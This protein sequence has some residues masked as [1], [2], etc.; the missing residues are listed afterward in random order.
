[1]TL[2]WKEYLAAGGIALL[3]LL[4]A[5]VNLP[6]L[7]LPDW[8]KKILDAMLGAWDSLKAFFTNSGTSQGTGGDILAN[9][10]AGGQQDTGSPVATAGGDPGGSTSGTVFKGNVPYHAQ[11]DAN[12]E[13]IPGTL[14]AIG[15]NQ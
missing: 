1:M 2:T 9:Q 10:G 12:G 7:S 4:V 14:Q 11:F 15:P 3:A 5:Y 8:L 13:L 6:S